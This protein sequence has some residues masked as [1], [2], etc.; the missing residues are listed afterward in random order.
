MGVADASDSRGV[1]G[2]SVEVKIGFSVIEEVNEGV[3]A[4]SENGLVGY[5]LGKGV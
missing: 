1:G 5:S 4:N 3:D 2:V